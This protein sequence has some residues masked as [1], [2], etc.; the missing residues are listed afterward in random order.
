M[1]QFL[2]LPWSTA[3]E[4][5]RRA[6]H[7]IINLLLRGKFN[8]RFEGTL[9]ANAASTTFRNPNLGPDSHVALMPLTAN[10]AAALA[11][12]Y[13]TAQAQG[14]ITYAHTNNSQTDRDFRFAIQ[15]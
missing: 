9:A 2:G 13:P 3:P 8:N 12:T 1:G 5:W 11:T 14:E 4:I 15:G 6:A 10:A 7:D